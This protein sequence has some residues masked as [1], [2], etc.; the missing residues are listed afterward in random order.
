MISSIPPRFFWDFVMAGWSAAAKP[1][2]FVHVG[3]L[4]NTSWAAA[5]DPRTR[6]I[7]LPERSSHPLQSAIVGDLCPATGQTERCFLAPGLCGYPADERPY[8]FIHLP[9]KQLAVV[10]FTSHEAC[11]FCFRVMKCIAGAEGLP[12]CITSGPQKTVFCPKESLGLVTGAA[13]EL[14]GCENACR[15]GMMVV[16]IVDYFV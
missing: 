6:I 15:L 1:P 11:D 4:G 3:V 9:W 14:A 2:M 8:N 13:N 10:N 16:W 5:W 7:G 12:Q